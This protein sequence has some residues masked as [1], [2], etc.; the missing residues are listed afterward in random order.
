M[1][2]AGRVGPAVGL[3]A[4]V[5]AA[6]LLATGCGAPASNAADTPKGDD[7]GDIT[8]LIYKFYDNMEKNQYDKEKDVLADGV[9]VKNPGGGV[10]TGA[11]KVIAN[12]SAAAKNEDRTQHVVTNV[13]VDVNGDKATAQADVD[14]LFGSSKTPQGKLAPEPTMRL[15]SKMHFEA[16]RTANGWRVSHIEGDL[17][18]AVQK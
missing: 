11:D 7:R 18:W 8:Q 5:L 3:S 17:L 14:Q 16:T 15:S 6:A 2:H 12:A 10:T 13:I 9:T 1:K 4:T